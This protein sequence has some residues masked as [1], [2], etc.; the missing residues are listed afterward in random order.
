MVLS[1]DFG[2]SSLKLSILD[3][4]SIIRSA[5]EDYNYLLLPGER[6]EM[7]PRAL[8]DALARACAQIG[9]ELREQVSLFCY[10]A[11]SPSLVMMDAEGDVLTNILTHMDRRSRKQSEH[12]A[13][14]FDKDRFQSIA[15]VYPFCGGVSVTALLWFM[16]NHPELTRNIYRIGHL[17]TYLYRRLTGEWAVDSANASMTGLYNTVLQS[18]WSHEILDFFGIPPLWLPD[19]RTPGEVL[20]GL[21]PDQAERLGLRANIPVALGTNDMAAAQVGAG[22]DRSGQILNSAGSSDMVSVLTDRPALNGGYYVRNAATPGLWQIYATT[23][24]GFALDWFYT[25]FC[26]EMSKAEFYGEFLPES[27]KHWREN[28][29]EFDPYLAEDRQSLE[30]RRGAWRSLTLATTKSQMLTAVM[31]A[32]QNVLVNTVKLAAEQIEV[33]SLIKV[34]GG[35][36]DDA[37]MTLKQEMFEGFRF[38][39]REDC[40]ILGNAALALR[41][42]EAAK[43]TR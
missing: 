28:T 32:M 42:E 43:I 10:D 20:G 37:V 6:A 14:V 39:Q 5:K 9:P 27:L 23:S 25:Q 13:A 12:I 17:A 34:T 11:F 38:E 26:G 40:T 31:T 7:E 19:I 15:G 8:E 36:A 33:D 30:R 16:E 22:N 18:G 41:A 29:V 24:G 2:T 21:L 3:G 35:F 1:V 4:G